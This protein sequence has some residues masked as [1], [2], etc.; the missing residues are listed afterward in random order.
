[1][2][3]G[4][5]GKNL[6]HSWSKQIHATFRPYD[7]D[8]INLSEAEFDDFMGKKG[9]KG[10]NVTI[11]YKQAVMPYCDTI[12]AE[13]LRIGSVNTIVRSH[14]GKL[15]GHNTDYAG[16]LYMI[17][18]ANIN[19]SGKN[20][21]ILGNGGTSLT[22]RTAVMD[23]GATSIHIVTRQHSY[24]ELNQL[25]DCDILINTT[26]VGMYPENG[27]YYVKLSDFPSCTGVVDVIYNPLRTKLLLDAERAGIP[28]TN[29]LPMLVAQAKY[30]GD[31]FAD[32]SGSDDK[33][34]NVAEKIS[35]DF[36]N[37][38]LVGMPGCGKTTVGKH[39]AEITGKSFVDTDS[40]I[41]KSAG[42]SIPQLLEIR[43]E[44]YF[45]EIES[46]VISEIG[47]ENGLVVSTGG[48][49]ILKESN[50]D[51]MRQN[52]TIIWIKRPLE[53]LCTKGRP[54]SN[55]Y[56]KLSSLYSERVDLYND[57]SHIDVENI[58]GHPDETAAK[59]IKLSA[60][61]TKQEKCHEPSCN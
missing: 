19:V 10:I 57:F 13:A 56:E 48:G 60:L 16:F 28:H 58:E 29:G 21:V 17:K 38:I 31:I 2:E 35:T 42:C 40:E 52:G 39:L 18:Q 34:A 55:S 3:Y 32:D 12:S 14:D 41:E 11:P 50:R 47:K 46:R 15:H 45:R 5:I 61:Q 8:L 27:S 26:P 24:D 54:L 9:F 6:T 33:I 36:S 43:G 44:S 1:M 7:Y 25:K 20:I 51:S 59:I 23:G 53:L 37:F 4:L 22:A 30:A 49:A